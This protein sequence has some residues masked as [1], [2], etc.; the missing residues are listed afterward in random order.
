[1]EKS[2]RTM[3]RRIASRGDFERFGLVPSVS[4]AHFTRSLTPEG[5]AVLLMAAAMPMP[6]A[7]GLAQHV[8]RRFNAEAVTPCRITRATRFGDALSRCICDPDIARPLGLA[9]IAHDF[10]SCRLVWQHHEPSEFMEAT[11]RHEWQLRR[12]AANSGF[13]I[14]CLKLSLLP[15]A[16]I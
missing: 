10:A 14:G 12:D 8:R 15:G 7:L 11:D 5:I 6:N 16:V 13:G 2:W 3:Q 4:G 1:T 9:E